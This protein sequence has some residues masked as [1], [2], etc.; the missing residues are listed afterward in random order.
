M[1]DTM[2][3]R[4]RAGVRDVPNFPKRGIVFKDITPILVDS[5]LF[6]ES[7]EVF[8]GRCRNLDSSPPTEI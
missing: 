7:V 6:H 4:L 1:A 3:E 2:I 5:R 8:L